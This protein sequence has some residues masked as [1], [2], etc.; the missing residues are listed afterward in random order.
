MIRE[1]SLDI[2]LV[3]GVAERSRFLHPQ[4]KRTPGNLDG[5][6]RFQRRDAG[7]PRQATD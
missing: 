3:H 1:T 6:T 4:L 7:V 2:G 5:L